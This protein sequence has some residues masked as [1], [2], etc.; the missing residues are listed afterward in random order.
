MMRS[1]LHSYTFICEL[2]VACISDQ[3]FRPKRA[4]SL[5]YLEHLYPLDD[6]RQENPCETYN[7]SRLASKFNS[8]I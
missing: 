8:G 3:N 1:I 7:V 6:A 4:I 2:S 5:R